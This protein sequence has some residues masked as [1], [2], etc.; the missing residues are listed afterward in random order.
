MNRKVLL[1]ELFLLLLKYSEGLKMYQ[2]TISIPMEKVSGLHFIASNISKLHGHSLSACVRFNYQRF[3]SY[4]GATILHV[5]DLSMKRPFI[6]LPAGYPWTFPDLG[7]YLK[8]KGYDNWILREL[9]DN[10]VVWKTNTW[11]HI[12]LSYSDLNSTIIVVKVSIKYFHKNG[13][14]QR[15]YLVLTHVGSFQIP[16]LCYIQIPMK[17]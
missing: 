10:Y 6:N 14:I 9:P 13:I 2:S 12:C 5:G 4:T 11:H 7:E 3:K 16:F 17:T 1:F 15:V 8:D